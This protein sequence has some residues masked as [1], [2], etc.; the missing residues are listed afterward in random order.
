[1]AATVWSCLAPAARGDLPTTHPSEAPVVLAGPA[2]RRA[3]VAQPRRRRQNRQRSVYEGVPW[4]TV[5]VALLLSAAIGAAGA[6]I[7]VGI[8]GPDG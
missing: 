4:D 8:T 5:A 1:M 3:L 2:D 6:K 7:Y